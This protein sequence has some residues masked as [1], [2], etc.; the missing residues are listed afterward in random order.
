MEQAF[1]AGRL[2]G[3]P[4]SALNARSEIAEKGMLSDIKNTC[5][6]ISVLMQKYG[7]QCKFFMRSISKHCTSANHDD[8]FDGALADV[9]RCA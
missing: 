5:T 1:K 7:M 6:N 3:I 4:E 9:S 8:R 2:I